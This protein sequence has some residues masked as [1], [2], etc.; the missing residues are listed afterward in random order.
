M[1]KFAR[2]LKIHRKALH[3]CVL[4]HLW[5]MVES[6]S[7]GLPFGSRCMRCSTALSWQNVLWQVCTRLSYR[8]KADSVTFQ[9]QTEI[10]N[11]QV[12]QICSTEI[13]RINPKGKLIKLIPA[14]HSSSEQLFMNISYA[15]SR[16]ALKAEAQH[17]IETCRVPG[18]S[19]FFGTRPK[20]AWSNSQICSDMECTPP[21]PSSF[22]FSLIFLCQWADWRWLKWSNKNWLRKLLPVSSSLNIWSFTNGEILIIMSSFIV[23]FSPEDMFEII[24]MYFLNHVLRLVFIR[25]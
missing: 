15:D 17:A 14:E 10:C 23:K 7:Q 1:C 6:C 2:I 25:G 4:L 20:T 19:D 5:A 9:E 8:I 21:I 11:D 13:L 12:G 18:N 3:F 22:S 24:T 16:Q